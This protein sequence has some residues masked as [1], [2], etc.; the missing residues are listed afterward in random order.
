MSNFKGEGE[1]PSLVQDETLFCVCFCGPLCP[2]ECGSGGQG[3]PDRVSLT[4]SSNFLSLRIVFGDV[5]SSGDVWTL[6]L[7]TWYRGPKQRNDW[8]NDVFEIESTPFLGPR[9]ESFSS[10]QPSSVCNECKPLLLYFRNGLVVHS[11]RYLHLSSRE[12]SL[13]KTL[14]EPW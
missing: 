13:P 10:S 6:P 12:K 2:T 8:R 1:C 5:G 14:L 7:S 11:D 4:R 3:F 9:I